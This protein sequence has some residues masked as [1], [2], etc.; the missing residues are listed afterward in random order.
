MGGELSP[1]G[2]RQ[3][4]E[5]IRNDWGGDRPYV[6]KM[7]EQAREFVSQRNA[8]ICAQYRAGER[9]ALLARRH[10]LSKRRVEQIIR[11]CR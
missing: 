2:L 8:L 11:S 6:P 1:E 10:G 5:E 3:L 7:G 9:V 4:E